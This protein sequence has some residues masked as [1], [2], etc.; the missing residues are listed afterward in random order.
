MKNYIKGLGI[1]VGEFKEN[2]LKQGI[3]KIKVNEIMQET[4]LKYTNSK[5][6]KNSIKIWV[7]NLEDFKI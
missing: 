3:D 1:Y 6:T 5:V 2:D 4:G 7:C